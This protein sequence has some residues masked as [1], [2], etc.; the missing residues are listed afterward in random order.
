MVSPLP[1]IVELPQAK[2]A[3][4]L[5]TSSNDADLQLRLDLAHEIVLDYLANRIDDSSDEWLDTILGWTIDNAPR[6]VVG[7]ILQQFVFLNRWRGDDE[8]KVQPELQNGMPAS[9]RMML[10]RLRDPTIA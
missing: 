7:A 2:A 4:R 5:T 8:A 6:R 3:A 1:V 9:V 10:D